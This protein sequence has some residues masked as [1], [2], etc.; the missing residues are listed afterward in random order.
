MQI[1]LLT[2]KFAGNDS[3]MGNKSDTGLWLIKN[4]YR[5]RSNRDRLHRMNPFVILIKLV[6]AHLHTMLAF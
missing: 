2:M 3:L 1:G 4:W 5:V 6:N